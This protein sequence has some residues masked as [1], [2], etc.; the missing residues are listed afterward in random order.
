MT[1][2][3]AFISLLD[4]LISPLF[5][6]KFDHHDEPQAVRAKRRELLDTIPRGSKVLEVGAGTGSTLV[7][8]AYEGSAGRFTQLILSEPDRGM[9]N[10]LV[11]KLHGRASGASTGELRVVDAALP[12]LPFDDASFDVVVLFFVASH[13]DHRAAGVSEIARVLSPHGKLLLLDHGVDSSGAQ[14]VH[15]PN[16]P[17]APFWRECLR[18]WTRRHTS[19]D[20]LSVDALLTTFR[21]DPDLEEVFATRMPAAT[22][23]FDEVVSGCYERRV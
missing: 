19:H 9:R 16:E 7:A 1:L 2:W 4:A 3:S 12:S 17:Q 18:F 13:V 20:H 21:S 23:Y 14:H 11:S 5:A 6:W 8:G 22:A 10:R 15:N